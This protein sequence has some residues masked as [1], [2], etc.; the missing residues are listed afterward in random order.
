MSS[1]EYMGNLLALKRLTAPDGGE[2][3]ETLAHGKKV[4]IER[5]VSSGQTTPE[6]E[7]YDQEQDEWVLL[8]QGES[9]IQW[10]CGTLSTL[11]EGD[12]LLIPAHMRHRVVFTSA[13]PPCVWLA[14]H[15]EA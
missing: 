7:W 5:I 13:D 12:W 15:F 11:K 6:N 8:L 14:V 9:Q 2:L 4:R 1:N 3:F 10:C